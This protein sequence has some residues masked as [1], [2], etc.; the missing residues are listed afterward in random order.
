MSGNDTDTGPA[1]FR[2]PPVC[3]TSVGSIFFHV[4]ARSLKFCGASVAS[5]RWSA[6]PSLYTEAVSVAWALSSGFVL[7]LSE[8]VPAGTDSALTWM[9]VLGLAAGTGSR[10]SRGMGGG[11]KTWATW[12]AVGEGG[13]GGG[14]ALAALGRATPPGKRKARVSSETSSPSARRDEREKKRN[15]IVPPYLYVEEGGAEGGNRPA[16]LT[17]PIPAGEGTV[18]PRPSDGK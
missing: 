7:T 12:A 13:G 14:A 2:Y 16:R 3:L 18:L 8:G 11:G 10:W 6:G 17:G 4:P 1:A 15:P 5:S 9:S